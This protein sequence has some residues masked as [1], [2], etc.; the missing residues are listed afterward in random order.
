MTSHKPVHLL[1]EI[2]IDEEYQ[3]LVAGHNKKNEYVH[4][5]GYCLN[6]IRDILMHFKGK[7]NIAAVTLCVI[8]INIMK[9]ILYIFCGW[10]KI[11]LL[12]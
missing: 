11:N 1:N 10:L 3:N 5:T 8:L 9:V 12:I 6:Y 4:Q 2:L 7:N